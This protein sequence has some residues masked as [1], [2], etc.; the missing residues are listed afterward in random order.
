MNDEIEDND[1]V[2]Y[3]TD[4]W[5]DIVSYSRHNEMILCA[6]YENLDINIAATTT[7]YYTSC[8]VLTPIVKNLT[9]YNRNE[10]VHGNR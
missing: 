7:D 8:F 3:I 1:L 10:I 2:K 4:N 5:L 9:I 6:T